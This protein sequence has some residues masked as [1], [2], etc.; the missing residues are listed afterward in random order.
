MLLAQNIIRISRLLLVF[1]PSTLWYPSTA[2][3]TV[4]FI[5]NKTVRVALNF[6]GKGTDDFQFSM[7]SVLI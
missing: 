2:S 4:T 6:F 3:V 7:L 5:M 1:I